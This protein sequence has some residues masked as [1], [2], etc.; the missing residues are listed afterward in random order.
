VVSPKGSTNGDGYQS[1]SQIDDAEV[2]PYSGSVPSILEYYNGLPLDDETQ[3]S[4]TTR[5][6]MSAFCW[7]GSRACANEV[8]EQPHVPQPTDRC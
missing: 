6:E 4:M 1:V 3:M 2:H 7:L 8:R 5:E